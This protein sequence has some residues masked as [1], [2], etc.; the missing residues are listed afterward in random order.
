M[1]EVG[2]HGVTRRYA[3]GAAPAVDALD[4]DVRDGELMVLV[5]PSG[6]GKSTALRMLAGLEDVDEGRITIGERDVT[7]LSPGDRD[8]AMVFQDYALYPHLTVGENLAFPLRLTDLPEQDVTRAVQESATVL[9]LQELLERKPGALSGGQRQR[10]AMGRAIVRS[11]QVFCMDEPLSNLDAQLRASTRTEIVALQ[12]RLGVTTVYVTHDQVEAMTMGDRIAVLR[13]GV[14]QQVDAPR[15]LYERP[16]NTFVAG[17]LGTPSMNLLD[18]Q[19]SDGAAQL[20]GWSTRLPRDVAAAVPTD[21]RLVVGVRPEH[22]VLAAD[23]DGLRAVVDVVEDV[24][25]DVVVHA[26]LEGGDAPTRVVLRVL[27]EDAPSKGTA[28]TLRPQDGRLSFFDR[29]SGLRLGA[30]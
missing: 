22:L 15:A 5:G 7:S 2:F 17:F 28:V 6:S 20:G 12:A 25:S 16:V 13:D 14:L 8:V 19:A 29:A 24:G 26:S 9:G 21:A 3:E 11:P 4:L 1:A 30:A 10:V 18:A 23:G 27:P